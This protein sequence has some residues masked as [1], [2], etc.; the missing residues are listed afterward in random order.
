MVSTA[1]FPPLESASG[2]IGPED[3]LAAG[4][5]CGEGGSSLGFF[6]IGSGATGVCG[7]LGSVRLVDAC[8]GV[9]S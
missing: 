1:W 8:G 5:G 2:R 7:V 6:K 3:E 9:A 4:S